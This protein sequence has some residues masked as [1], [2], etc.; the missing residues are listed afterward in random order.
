MPILF[1]SLCNESSLYAA[2]NHIR[3]KG[4]SGG[5]DGIG[6]DAFHEARRKEIPRLARELHN[7]SWR[8]QPYL[9]IEVSKTKNPDEVR[10]LGMASMRDKV[11]Q[12]AIK[13]IIEP[14]LERLFRT[15][16][17]GYRPGKGATKA[18]R[19]ALA[20]CRK[21]QFQW[22]LR[23]D[24][25]NFFDTIDHTILLNR[26]SATGLEQDIIRLIMLC[27]QMGRVQGKGGSW[28][29][30]TRGV[31]Q[32][33]IL[34]PLLSNLYLNS[35]DQFAESRGVPYIRYADD[36]LFLTPTEEQARDILQRTTQHLQ[37]KLRLS[38]NQPP[39]LL[40]LADGFD[41]LGINIRNASATITNDKREELCRRI[42]TFELSSDGLDRKSRKTWTG[43]DN[44]YAQLLPQSDLEHLDGSL[45]AR[46]ADVARTCHSEFRTQA[47]FRA[48]V[49]QVG[50]LSVEY[51]KQKKMWIDELLSIFVNASKAHQ[52]KN[53]TQLNG[54]IIQLRKQEYRR[55][56]A[57]ASGLLVNKPGTFIGL[58]NRGVTVSQK[59]KVL[60]QHHADNL[61]QIVVTGQGVSLSSNLIAF[62]LNRRIPVDFF[63]AQGSHL[64]SVVSARSL[65]NTLWRHQALAPDYTRNAIALKIIEGKIKNQHALL[66][67]YHKY[68]KDHYP[69]LS[70]KMA[71]MEVQVAQFKTWK[72]KAKGDDF[73]QKLTGHESQVAIRYWDYV[74][75]LLADDNVTF[76]RREHRGATDLINSML[77]YG[78]ALLYVR[79]WQALLSAGLNPFEGLVHAR[80]ENKPA[81]V[82]DFVELFRSQIVDRIVISLVQRGHELEVR[83]GLLTDD[84]R[85]LLVKSIMERLA[86][87]EKHRGQEM[88]MATIITQ[89]AKLLAA[90][91][92]GEADF[93]PYVAKW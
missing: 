15:C 4:A 8:P 71:A 21:S 74:R 29:S 6:V 69:S 9:E 47:A 16:S 85:L 42:W 78:Y 64:G 56:E 19:R 28:V 43:M 87:Y 57:E 31:P 51:R 92:A 83:N 39:V 90:T 36:F 32:G 35:F 38:L 18:I 27:V 33:A 58:T 88:K 44:Y 80:A 7:G 72:T 22:V 70:E 75:E 24:I 73:I 26:L 13:N 17:Y 25:D 37:E 45:Y 55:K 46:L 84:T 76:S 54:R 34:S 52:Q 2:W 48:A 66:K 30:N 14:R 11:V 65:Q 10:R 86:R 12:Q 67:Y 61:S 63:D 1:S 40:P 68:H 59:G 49:S 77:N 41:F 5:I 3:T 81:L 82:Y 60:S 23:L 91:F 79:S 62:C 20:E 93:K 53:N 50:F 89:Q